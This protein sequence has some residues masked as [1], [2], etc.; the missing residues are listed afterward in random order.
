MAF[1]W[2]L[3]EADVYRGESGE[4]ALW[5]PRRGLIITR[6]R[7]FG[8][9]ECARFYMA[10]AER[11]MLHGRLTV[12]HEWSGMEGYDPATRE[13]MKRWGKLHNAD[14]D[15]VQYLVRSKVVAMV[16]TVA[17]LT[18]GRDLLATTDREEFSAALERALQA[19][20]G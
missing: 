18:L 9:S 20:A 4:V 13:A 19:P 12:F 11:E 5:R 3:A 1:A 16:L 10:H 2:D 8:A 7:G 15:Q 6:L 14:F 17:A